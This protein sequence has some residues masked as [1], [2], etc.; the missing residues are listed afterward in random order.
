VFFGI[1]LTSAGYTWKARPPFIFQPVEIAAR[2]A[3][4]LK[5][6]SYDDPEPMG[7]PYQVQAEPLT[8][9]ASNGLISA[10]AMGG[11]SVVSI[12]PNGSTAYKF[13]WSHIT[14]MPANKPYRPTKSPIWHLSADPQGNLYVSDAVA[15]TI[16]KYSA[17]GDF[18]TDIGTNKLVN[19]QS[20]VIDN[21]GDIYII[22]NNIIKVI[23][24]SQ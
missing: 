16:H 21:S 24:A 12:R 9:G 18:I 13:S 7:Y 3:R 10:I 14:G 4:D 22:D 19:P 11:G 6:V 2:A 15:R 5:H 23:R 17:S 20:L 8:I 1:L